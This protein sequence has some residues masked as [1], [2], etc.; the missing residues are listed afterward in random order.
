MPGARIT[1]ERVKD[2]WAKDLPAAKGQWN[3]DELKFVYFLDNVLGL[4]GLQGGQARLL[5]RDRAPRTG[6]PASTSTPSSAGW[7]SGEDADQDACSPCRRFALNLRR[8]QFQDARVR[9]AFNLALNFEW[10]NKNLFY[11]AVRS[12]ST[13]TSATR[14]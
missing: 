6:R 2:W 14:S 1:Y 7:S 5:A 4:R 13:A 12:A 9:R 10:T 3:F 11:D 8:P